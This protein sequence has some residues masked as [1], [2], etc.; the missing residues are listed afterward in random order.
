MKEN[1]HTNYRKLSEPFPNGTA[2]NDA[3]NAFFEELYELRN[4]HKIRDVY[5]VVGGCV[6][7]PAE[8]NDPEIEADFITAF[9]AGEELKREPMVT[10]AVGYE[11]AASR[12]RINK[13]RAK[14]NETKSSRGTRN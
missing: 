5:V 3:I 10:W 1:D 7:Y 11:A 2:A 4:K 6:L 14:G 12:E 8:G 9:H 13:I